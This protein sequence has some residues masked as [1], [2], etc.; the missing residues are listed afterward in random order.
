MK[1]IILASLLVPAIAFADAPTRGP[2]FVRVA[3]RGVDRTVAASDGI[4]PIEPLE[5]VMF[6]LDST[7]LDPIALSE[8][9]VLARWL[10]RY[11][12]QHLVI[13][14]HT[15]ILGA[16]GYNIDLGK[17][18][19]DAV[20]EHLRSWGINGDRIVVASFGERDAHSTE[21]PGD[22][23]VV[24]FASDRPVQQLAQAM[25]DATRAKVVAW[26]DRGTKLE[27]EKGI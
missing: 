12:D 18:R 17:R 13:E 3:P 22:R 23:N 24:I 6:D 11:P 16:R 19:A 8:L 1:T 14:G 27:T 5:L 25:L 20:R 21:N 2:D 15:D 9:D 4:Q 7:A 10:K 26:S